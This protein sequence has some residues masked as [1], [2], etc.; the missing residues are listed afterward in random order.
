MQEGD[1]TGINRRKFILNLGRVAGSALI[2]GSIF[3]S[4]DLLATHSRKTI[5]S[6]IFVAKNGT[7]AENVA[8][9]IDMRFGG[10]ENFIGQ[11]DAVVI[12]PNG[13][14]TNQGGSNCACCMGLIDL[15]LNRPGL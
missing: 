3:N 12:N 9:V 15:I 10:I 4:S 8:K 2:G 13:Q 1:I 5:K 14:W 7:P 6:N 11:N